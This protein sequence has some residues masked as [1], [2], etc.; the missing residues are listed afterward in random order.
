MAKGWESKSVADQI[1]ASAGTDQ[2]NNKQQ[3]TLEQTEAHRRMEVLLLSR[4]RVERALQ[5]SQNPRYREQLMR[6][7]A[8]LDAQL[9]AM[10]HVGS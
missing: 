9:S 6:A 10:K 4:A 3:L 7:L 5:G 2:K 1:E 8:D